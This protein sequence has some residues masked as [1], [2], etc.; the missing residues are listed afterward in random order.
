MFVSLSSLRRTLTAFTALFALAA[1]SVSLCAQAPTSPLRGYLYVHDPSTIIECKGRYYDFYTAQGIASKSSADKVYWTPGP[2]VFT[3]VPAWTTNAVPGFTGIFWAPDVLYFN[4]TYHLWYAVST[5]GSQVSAIG[6]VTNPTLDP[7][8]PSYRWTDQGMVIQST[9][10]S[11]YNTI[12][13]SFCWDGS[14]NLWMAFGSYWN[15]IFLVQLNATTGLRI[16]SNSPTY[17]LAYNSSIEASYLFKRG[18]YYYLWANW[19]SCCDGVDSTYNIRM[20]RATSI[21]GPYLD[22]NGV[23][24]AANGGSVFQQ[25]NGKFTGPGHVGIFSTNGTQLWSYHYYDANAFAPQY[26]IYGEPALSIAPLSWTT[27]NWP[28]YSNNWSALYNFQADAREENGQYYGLLKNG[29]TVVTNNTY[30]HVLN[31]NGTN[32]YVW[33]PPG[34]A[35]GQTFVAVVNW[36]GGPAWQR[37]FD[38]GVN[39]GATVLLTPASDA[40]VLRCDINPGGNLQ[41]VQ[42]TS[43]LPSNVWT[44]VALT[45]NGSQGVIYVNGQPVVTNTSM[46]L[47]PFN[48]AP[49]SNALGQSKFT[50]DPYFNGQYAAF[51]VYSHALT[52][53]EIVQPVPEITQ[54][55]NGA[56]YWPGGSIQFAGRA[57]DFA[58]VP[59][60]ANS[61]SWQIQY[62]QDGVTNVVYGPVT[63][64]TNGSYT[65]PTNATGG[66]TYTIVLTA[67]DSSNRQCTVSTTLPP[68]NPPA[69][70]SSYYPLHSD[71][72]DAN[73]HYNGTLQNGAS[74]VNDAQR[75]PVLSLNGVNQYASFPPGLSGME[76]FMAWVKWN[77]GAP[78]QR[79]Y[80]FGNDTNYYSVL[81]PEASSGDLRFNISLNSIPGEQI[82]D[83]L[84]PLP[85][86]VWTHVAVVMNG[87]SVILYTNGVPVGTNLYANLVPGNL[88][89]TNIYFGKS[90]WAADPYFSGEL[91]DVRIFSYPLA[92][93]QI[94]A[95]QITINQ[96]ASGMVYAP[97]ATISYSG[98][99]NDFYDNAI[100]PG[101]LTWWVNY[102]NAGV[103]NLVS[104]PSTGASN[105]TFNIPASGSGST[106]GYY[107]FVLAAT[108]TNGTMA[109]NSVNIYPGASAGL[110]NWGSYYPFTNGAQDASNIYNGTLQGGAAIT[111]DLTRGKVL[112]LSG[113]GEYVSLPAGAGAA[114]TISGW[115]KWF[116]GSQWER[117]F[118]FGQSTNDYYFVTTS[119]QSNLVQCAIT[120]DFNVYSQQIESTTPFPT[121][122]WTYVSVVMDGRQG[123]LYLNG[124]AVGVNNSVNLLPSDLGSTKVSFG[125]SQYPTDPNFSGELSDFALNS[126]ALPL[127]YLVDPIPRITLP[128]SGA[129]FTGGGGINFAGAATDYAGNSLP[130]SAL[131]WTGLL[132]S[133]GVA[134]PA[135]GP[136]NGVTSGTFTVP[137]NGPSSTNY[138]YVVT[139]TA[140]DTNGNSQSTGVTVFPETAMLSLATAPNGLDVLLGGQLIP[141]GTTLPEIIGMNYVLSA[142]SPQTL[143]SSNYNFVLWSDGGPQTQ[144]ILISSNMSLTASFEWPTLSTTPS[145]SQW[146]VSWPGWAGGLH[147][148]AATNLTPPVAWQLVTNAVVSSNGQSVIALSPTNQVQFFRLQSP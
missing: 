78:W 94:T 104:G 119:D 107:Q 31:L 15:G 40:N 48:V 56:V 140:T 135:F 23:D 52:P 12:D 7:S 122:K 72:Q 18:G 96:P 147:L 37:I 80:D 79:I 32:Q 145:G 29:A 130:A 113:G 64:M 82:I 98:S 148:Y 87:Q 128:G 127:N 26:G 109:T 50:V 38:F 24:M 3:N 67:A 143:N 62:A 60:L 93:N 65:V 112:G 144:N 134:L 129:M 89:A 49:Q 20:G 8:D 85:V 61:F 35:Y 5:F 103:T 39:T 75:G 133:N 84:G 114:E 88:N 146:T 6:L 10:G 132:Y 86:G 142:P 45:L 91:S 14:G 2:P 120:A 36:H 115:V 47:L 123:I 74:F 76:T 71:V 51:R 108:A 63:G 141:D 28:F 116:G 9:N 17:H 111:S 69:G 70:W 97:G 124:V 139:L 55:A 43:P 11:P 118:D 101:G 54:P 83:A 30:G 34:V 77:G 105:G 19:G 27:N 46:N 126:T 44:H 1:L 125:K 68:A 106:N 138:Y 4:N 16:S 102:I 13:P 59:L 90:Q 42:W 81:T 131:S 100:A 136:S 110:T 57:T 121:N 41:T 95:P 99:A 22:Q 117:I 58:A 66:G 92:S 73:G 53:Q 21:T 25:A 33:L 137:T